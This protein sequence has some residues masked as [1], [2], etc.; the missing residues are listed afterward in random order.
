MGDSAGRAA[1]A[2]RGITLDKHFSRRSIRNTGV[3]SGIRNKDANAEQHE[4]AAIASGG[5]TSID[6]DGDA[7]C[8]IGDV[9]QNSVGGT[10]APKSVDVT[11]LS[12]PQ[13]S[14]VAR[15]SVRPWKRFSKPKW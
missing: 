7:K 2:R 12:P 1:L 5:R 11:T 10:P 15:L 9:G 3:L 13:T 6:A 4:T 8:A 14:R